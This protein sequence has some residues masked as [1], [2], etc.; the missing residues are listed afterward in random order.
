M[1]QSSSTSL[2]PIIST[3]ELFRKSFLFIKKNSKKLFY[4][5]LVMLIP[6]IIIQLTRLIIFYGFDKG[7]TLS[8]FWLMFFFW[9]ILALNII[10]II[11]SLFGSIALLIFINEDDPDFRVSSA[12][13][14]SFQKFFPYLWIAILSTLIVIG[15]LI[16][17]VIPGIFWAISYSL[18]IYILIT[19]DLRGYKALQR[20]KELIK[21][22]WWPVFF[23][24]ISLFLILIVFTLPLLFLESL[25]Q[26]KIIPLVS[27]IYELIYSL[28]FISILTIY[29]FYIYKDLKRI[30]G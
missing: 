24:N 6:R 5:I 23:R 12:F 25:I 19:E 17:F 20:S 13:K 1:A 9:F 4:I 8:D 10:S 11:V 2:P 18:G 14:M 22:Y 15:G 27:F 26:S 29:S 21:N 3:F 30:K 16:L 7:L 28:F